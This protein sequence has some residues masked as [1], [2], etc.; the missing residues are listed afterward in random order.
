MHEHLEENI[1]MEDV[2]LALHV[3]RRELEYAFRTVQDQSPRDYLQTLRLNAIRRV[4]LRVE[5]HDA[6]IID[7][8]QA[9]GMTHLGRFAAHYRSLFGES[10]SVTLRRQGR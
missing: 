2:C 9:H 5:N 10:P 7:V 4:L 6:S 8:A 3:S 1:R